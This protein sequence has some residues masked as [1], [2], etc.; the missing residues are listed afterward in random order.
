MKEWCEYLNRTK[1][2]VILCIRARW[3]DS[4]VPFI[5]LERRTD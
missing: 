1:V 4:R 3:F 5:K 2:Y